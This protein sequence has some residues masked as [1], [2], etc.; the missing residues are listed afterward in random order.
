MAILNGAIRLSGKLGDLVFYRRGKKTVA[1]RKVVNYKLSKNTK[2]SGKDFG[3][4]CRNACY[5][6]TAFDPLVK[7]FGDGTLPNR[8]NGK[9]CEVFRSIS[10]EHLGKKQLRMG[11][12]SMLEGFQFNP[13]ASLSDLLFEIPA[14]HIDSTDQHLHMKISRM[15]TERLIKSVPKATHALLKVMIFNFELD[16]D[17]YEIENLQEL[18]IPVNQREF[19]G[20]KIR[21]HLEQKGARAIIVAMGISYI[22]HD[23][24]NFN[25]RNFACGITNAIHLQDGVEKKW[26]CREGEKL[27]ELPMEQTLQ[28]WE[29]EE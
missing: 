13:E 7:Y 22:E 4:A 21:I 19:K 15:Y 25:K 27:P 17:L 1:R 28:Q 10:Q 6:R 2:K 8:L 24:R 11:N 26:I 18:R 20:A 29:V 5:I 12:I 23:A 14:V 9:V 16:G 3:N